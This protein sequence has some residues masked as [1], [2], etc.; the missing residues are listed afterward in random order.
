MIKVGITGGIGSG[1]TTIALFFELLGVPVYQ[2]DIR[3]KQLINTHPELIQQMKL[4]LGEEAYLK[5]AGLNKAFV[6][7]KIFKNQSLLDSVNALVH[8]AVEGDF[9]NFCKDNRDKPY[10][11]K[12]SAI[13]FETELYKKN[14]AN[15]LV[16]ADLEERI[17]RVQKRSGLSR[18]EVEQRISK[19][20]TDAQKEPLADYIIRNNN[21]ELL[22]PQ[23]LRIDQSLRV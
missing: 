8:P 18:S 5:D 9:L 11:L 15:I 19:Q 17:K 22:I 13:L 6:A 7:D 16:L 3:A 14:D 23:I 1:K 12:E 20:W 2:S 10:V 21:T 4:L